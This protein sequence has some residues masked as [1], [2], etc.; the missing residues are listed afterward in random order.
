MSLKKGAETAV[1]TCMGVKKGEKILILTDPERRNIGYELYR[2]AVKRSGLAY[3]FIMPPATRH[4]EEPPAFV[5][6]L[7]KRMD[8]VIAPTTYSITHTQA[9]K[10]ACRA[11]ARI[12]TMPGITEAMMSRGGMTANFKDIERS[13]KIMSKVLKK[14]KTARITTKLG[15]DIILNL[16]G[17]K[18]ITLD[19][20]IC[21]KKGTFT[22]LPAGEIFIAPKEG[23]AQGKIIIDGAFGEKLNDLITVHVK[24]G[25][26]TKISCPKKLKRGIEKQGKKARNIAE[27]GIGMNPKAKI[28]GNVLE[29]E[30]AKGTVHIALGD[31]STFGG[32]VKAGIHID[33]IIRSPTLVIND[34]IEIIKNGKMMVERI[35]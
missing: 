32:K 31:N 8:V 25:Y 14:A 3:F 27:L 29:D 19:N 28:I 20:G 24:D 4:G 33:G 6:Q 15:T 10:S 5:A 16:E 1:I 12:A 35:S 23:T 13:I 34:D 7:M 2:V 18:W 11:G 22:N 21:H 9:R 17:R 30:K 26:A